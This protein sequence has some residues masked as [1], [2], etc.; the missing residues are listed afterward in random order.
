MNTL[1]IIL[2][3]QTAHWVYAATLYCRFEIHNDGYNCRMLSEYSDRDSAASYVTGGHSYERDNSKV[4]VLY[5]PGSSNTKFLPIDVCTAFKNIQ[6]F[7]IKS[8]VLQEI[9]RKVFAKCDKVKIIFITS[10]LISSLPDN[11]FNDLI[12][13]EILDLSKNRIEYLPAKLF[14]N[15]LKLQ[16][17]SFSSNLLKIVNAKLP[18]SLTKAYFNSNVCINGD[19]N[20][21]YVTI[22]DLNVDIENK[23]MGESYKEIKEKFDLLQKDVENQKQKVKESEAES[24]A[25]KSSEKK[26]KDDLKVCNTSMKLKEDQLTSLNTTN[27]DLSK[28]ISNLKIENTQK[29]NEIQ[30]LTKNHSKFEDKIV[31]LYSNI[32]TLIQVQ[33]ETASNLAATLKKLEECDGNSQNLTSLYLSHSKTLLTLRIETDKLKRNY[34][35]MQKNNDAMTDDKKKLKDL[36]NNK[37]NETQVFQGQIA[38]LEGKNKELE[39]KNLDIDMKLLNSTANCSMTVENLENKLNATIENLQ[40]GKARLE[41]KLEETKEIVAE[42]QTMDSDLHNLK[43]IQTLL[44]CGLMISVIGWIVTAVMYTRMARMSSVDKVYLSSLIDRNN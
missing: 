31:E 15:N 3:L 17:I 42:K 11:V 20:V 23:C 35:E 26:A 40:K 37:Q 24:L 2:I 25:S 21:A 1:K 44:I 14:E 13:L 19:L 41:S 28:Q 8:P 29:L 12:S 9:S 36:L 32:T 22:R 5:I 33:Q 10:T 7:E 39:M 34:T 18:N 27:T 38:E 43:T 6:K 30:V 4:D 16:S